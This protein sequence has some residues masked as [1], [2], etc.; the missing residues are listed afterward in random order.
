MRKIL[1]LGGDGKSNFSV[2]SE[3]GLYCGN[4]GGDLSNI[5]NFSNFKR[6][7][8]EYLE[9]N[10][11]NPDCIACDGHPDYYSTQ[12]AMEFLKENKSAELFKIQHHFAHC[13]SCMFDNDIDEKVIGVA[14]DGTGYGTDG[15]LWGGEFFIC[16]R[17]NFRRVKHLKYISQPGGDL[18]SREG[19]RMAIAYLVEA[20]HH[21]FD[22]LHLPLLQRIG[23]KKIDI[24]QQMIEK[25]VNCPLA[26]SMGRLFDAISAII[27]I[28]DVSAFEGEAAVLLEKEISSCIDDHYSYSVGEEEIDVLSML[29]EIV[30]DFE[31]TVE[32]NI[33]SAKFHNTVGEII[34]DVANQISDLAGIGKVVVSGGCFQNKY[35]TEYITKKFSDSKL[36]LFKHRRYS[37]TDISLSVGQAAVAAS[38]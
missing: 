34:F 26:S 23:K 16:D 2:V 12:L 18:A 9:D 4:I 32:K 6:K 21:D 3:R 5:E 20:Y 14:F 10:D 36:K 37:P 31:N 29:K 38:V 19:W 24:V 28:C 27:D 15:N 25:E 7:I 11:I 1:A 22:Q 8:N 30:S 35:L 33:I 13:V 17:K